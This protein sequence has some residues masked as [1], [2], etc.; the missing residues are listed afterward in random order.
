MRQ[1][2]SRHESGTRELAEQMRGMGFSASAIEAMRAKREAE[3]VVLVLPE[4][5]PTLLLWFR[6]ANLWAYTD[7]GLKIALDWGA[8]NGKLA[9][10]ERVEG[11]TVDATMLHYLELFE[12][13]N[14]EKQN[15]EIRQRR[16]D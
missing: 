5:W 10:L 3:N 14:L 16:N 2:G 8:V 11:L 15:D 12:A 1:W 13:L 7:K 4:L 9:L 6:V